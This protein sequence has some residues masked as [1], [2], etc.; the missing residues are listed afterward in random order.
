M[1]PPRQLPLSA[2]IEIA[3]SCCEQKDHRERAKR[4]LKR[5]IKSRRQAQL[6]PPLE[7]QDMM[8]WRPIR[9]FEFCVS[10]SIALT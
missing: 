9:S 2:L 7:G 4:L 1:V 3:R 8:V 5:P 10:R 6:H